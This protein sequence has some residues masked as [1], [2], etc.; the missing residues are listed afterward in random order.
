MIWL[1]W[2]LKVIKDII[3][4][5]I[6]YFCVN[7]IIYVENC[8]IVCE[9]FLELIFRFRFL[10]KYVYC[11]LVGLKVRFGLLWFYFLVCSDWVI[12]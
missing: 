7:K 8:I 3:I 6:S 4:S 2:V 10:Y 1:K 5:I 9:F 11:C 12:F